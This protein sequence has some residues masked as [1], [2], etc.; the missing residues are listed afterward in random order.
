MSTR[1]SAAKVYG[2]VWD[3]MP[4]SPSRASVQNFRTSPVIARPPKDHCLC[5]YLTLRLVGQILGRSSDSHRP[6]LESSPAQGASGMRDEQGTGWRCPDDTFGGPRAE[7]RAGITV[8][9]RWEGGMS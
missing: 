7:A 5:G 9:P 2:Y 8:V 4:L 6:P 3:R 1:H